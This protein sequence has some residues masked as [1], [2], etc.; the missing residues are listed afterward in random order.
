MRHAWEYDYEMFCEAVPV[1][2]RTD[3]IQWDGLLEGKMLEEAAQ[4]LEN[5]KGAWKKAPAGIQSALLENAGRDLQYAAYG[6]RRGGGRTADPG[7]F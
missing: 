6:L 5:G 4:M 1:K 3:L 2:D 7:S